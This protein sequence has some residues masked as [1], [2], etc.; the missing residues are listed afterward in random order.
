MHLGRKEPLEAGSRNVEK[1]AVFQV[2][3]LLYGTMGM[4]EGMEKRT[5]RTIQRL[6]LIGEKAEE[7]RKPSVKESLRLLQEGKKEEGK[8]QP[9]GKRK[10]LC[11]SRRTDMENCLSK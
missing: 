10:C 8:D 7:I 5:D 9:L 2:Q 4:L 1:G 3:K 6:D 11:G